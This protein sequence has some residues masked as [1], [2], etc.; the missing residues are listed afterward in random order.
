MQHSFDF[1]AKVDM[2]EEGRQGMAQAA[3]NAEL[4]EPGWGERALTALHRYARVRLAVANIRHPDF[5]A[6]QARDAI[7]IESPTDSR[8]WG[9]VVAKAIRLG[10]IEKTGQFA[11]A[12]SS[13]GSPKPLYRAGRS[14]TVS[15]LG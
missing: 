9:A 6:E 14:L 15:N 3:A 1:D 12:R 8:A 11:P 4:V 13:H 10:Y 2:F 5:T 7:V